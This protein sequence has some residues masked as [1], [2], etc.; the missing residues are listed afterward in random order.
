MNQCS[1]LLIFIKAQVTYET[2]STMKTMNLPIASF[3][4]HDMDDIFYITPQGA[5]NLNQ[6][7]IK[8]MPIIA[9]QGKNQVTKK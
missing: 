9:P 2:N 7:H 8:R 6:R 4:F 3:G 1:T 5:G